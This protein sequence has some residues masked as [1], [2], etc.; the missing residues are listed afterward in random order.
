MKTKPRS[1]SDQLGKP[2]ENHTA[3]TPAVVR[4]PPHSG[5]DGD[6]KA[7]L[8]YWMPSH[9]PIGKTR[10]GDTLE[11]FH[12]NLNR[13]WGIISSFRKISPYSR[14]SSFRVHGAVVPARKKAFWPVPSFCGFAI[15]QGALV[16][17]PMAWVESHIP[18]RTTR[19]AQPHRCHESQG[20][21]PGLADGHLSLPCSSSPSEC[22]SVC[23]PR[24]KYANDEFLCVTQEL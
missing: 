6:K 9:P 15:G 22:R 17:Q 10:Q 11:G 19:P 16:Y 20:R 2:F 5:A 1:L 4:W 14:R 3:R 13:I 18:G 21:R 7:A 8:P 23:T 12:Q 24:Q